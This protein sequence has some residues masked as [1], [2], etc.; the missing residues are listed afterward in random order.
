MCGLAGIYV[1]DGTSAEAHRDLVDAMCATIDHRGPDDRGV[2]V[3]GPACLGSV[4]LKILD[5]SAAG[6]MPMEV[7]PAEAG[8]T[9][10]P[11]N[12]RP[13]G[14]LVYNGEVYN[15][16]ALRD[17]LEGLGHVFRS[18]SDTEVVLHAWQE[19]GPA[20][21]ERFVGMF[22]FAH[23]DP[24][25]E[26]LN[27]LRDRF[28]IK[29][30][31][32]MRHEG[33]LAFASETKAF[34]PLQKTVRLNERR[35]L[36]WSLYQN[37]DV[38]TPEALVE[39][40]ESVLPGERVRIRG[41]SLERSRWYAPEERVERQRFDAR[42]KES[43]DVV[44]RR[45]EE[46][47]STAVRDRL[48]SDVP[49]GTLLSGGLDSSL[50]SALAGRDTKQ[51][52]GFHVAIEGHPEHDESRFARQVSGHLG[53]ELI[54]L[55]LNGERFR[56]A[57]VRTIAACE[58]P[59]E[60]PNSVAYGLICEVARAHGVIVLLSGEGADELF[61]GYAWRYH[62]AR[63]L[64]RVQRWLERLPRKLRRALELAGYASAGLP[65]T[66]HRIHELLPHAVS[67]IDRHARRA[68]RTRCTSAYDF[69][70]DEA[71]RAMLG[72]ML[73]DLSGFLTP[74]LRR[75]DRTSM[76]HSIECRVPFLDHRLV[77][78][79]VH[80]PLDLRVGR[81]RDKKRVLKRIAARH[82]PAG[83]VDRKKVGF[84]LPLADYVAPLARPELFGG[85]CEELFGLTREGLSELLA[86][87]PHNPLGFLNLASWEI[88]GR[89]A[90]RGEPQADVEALVAELGSAR[91]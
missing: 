27:L 58:Q 37:V 59:L 18:T 62:R 44:E 38:L 31:F 49:V 52:T 63:R 73:S 19:W 82:L 12:E 65:V 69:V 32:V 9:G 30:L 55:P 74:L 42:A 22:A 40:I 15:F 76:T 45:I 23:W 26:E 84:P 75:L 86:E 10:A 47:L 88:W 7:R 78:E 24:A 46:L 17:E 8:A 3:S 85:V 77:E 57:L 80:L 53:I 90:L 89:M 33:L 5:L 56:G 14:L 91:G 81:G 35:F 25:S 54:E 43:E 66:T 21:V 83:I 51:L 16:A 64:T 6:H 61:G 41:G 50:V 71:D 70:S 28:G 87:A 72:L 39:G 29:P 4:R 1:L 60:H 79:A 48:V 67:L 20:C 2:V 36:E 68:W 13:G 34:A 11:L